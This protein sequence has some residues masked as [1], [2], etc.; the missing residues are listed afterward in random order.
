ML[1]RRELVLALFLCAGCGVN[2]SAPPPAEVQIPST[3][4]QVVLPDGAMVV[5]EVVSDPET[6]ALGLMHRPSL[7]ADRGLLF[8]FP[9]TDVH[10]F[11]MKD[12]LIPLD[13]VWIDESSRVVDVKTSVPPCKADPC[14]SYEPAG[15]ARYVLELAADQAAAHR[16]APGSRLQIRNTGQYIIR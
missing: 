8:L 13:M 10:A 4:P 14:P 15:A 6:R 2:S 9:T 7:R 12:T 16:V 1:L 5:V 11:W 3:A